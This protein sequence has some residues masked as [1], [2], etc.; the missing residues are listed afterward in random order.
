MDADSGDQLF[1][2]PERRF[3]GGDYT[4]SRGVDSRRGQHLITV[5]PASED[6]EVP[7]R[8][9]EQQRQLGIV[10]GGAACRDNDGVVLDR[11][12]VKSVRS[13]VSVMLPLTSLPPVSAITLTTAPSLA[14]ALRSLAIPARSDSGPATTP[15]TRLAIEP[16]FPADLGESRRRISSRRLPRGRPQAEPGRDAGA[17][18]PVDVCQVREGA[19]SDCLLEALPELK[20]ERLDDMISFDLGQTRPE[21]GRL[22]EVI[23]EGCRAIPHLLKSQH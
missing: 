6:L 4:G 9:G 12:V 1:K 20:G 7:V 15:T 19:L 21:Q 23:C 22:R 10:Q 3:C 16:G 5:A 8:L 17:Q 2:V 18:F 11:G 14:S 13:T